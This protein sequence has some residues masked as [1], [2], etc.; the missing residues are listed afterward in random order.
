MSPM[1]LAPPVQGPAVK[2]G[3]LTIEEREM[4]A[5]GIVLGLSLRAIAAMLPGNRSHTT[6]MREITR[7][8]APGYPI[9]YRADQRP[10][11]AER[12]MGRPL[13]VTP[14]L[15]SR[16]QRNAELRAARPRALKLALNTRLRNEVQTRL[17]REESPEQIS[18]RLIVAFPDDPEM[19][20]AAETIY[21]SLYVQ[22]KGGLRR[23]LTAC[24][25]TGRAK[26]RPHRTQTERSTNRAEKRIPDLVSISQRPAEA[27]DRA[28]PGHWEGDLITGQLNKT[29]IGTLVERTTGFVLLLHLPNGHGALAVQEAMITE[30]ARLPATL[31]RTLTWDRGIEMRNHAHIAEATGLH[32]YFCDPHSPWQRGT[33]ENTNGLLRQYFPKGTDLSVYHRDYLDFIAARLNNRPRKR[34]GFQTPA[35]RLDQLLSQPPTPPTGALTA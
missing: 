23:E 20:V 28:V 22:G 27:E 31:L 9:P 24:L 13:V 35:E 18:G 5:V 26:R 15:A 17:G 29:A 2:G 1:C 11:A 25:R 4:I 21:K 33:N 6:V 3:P 7:S 34:H 30:M 19:R 10:G 12:V 8:L 16:G 32:I 14:Y